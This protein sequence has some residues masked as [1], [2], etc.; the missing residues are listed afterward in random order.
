MKVH[1]HHQLESRRK[2][3]FYFILK[4]NTKNIKTLKLFDSFEN[5]KNRKRAS[6]PM[7]VWGYTEE[8]RDETFSLFPSPHRERC[9]C[10]NF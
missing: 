2:T 3:S 6:Q 4:K 1:H 8:N 5:D 7:F 9:V 10:R